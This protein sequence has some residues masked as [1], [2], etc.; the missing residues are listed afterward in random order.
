[1]S[2]RRTFHLL[3]AVPHYL[4]S[5]PYPLDSLCINQRIALVK[6][7][8]EGHESFVLAGMQRLIERDHPV[9]IV[10]TGSKEVIANLKSLGYI[11]EKLQNSPNVLF[12]PNI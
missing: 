2:S 3:Q 6:I 12:K 5:H 8:V 1:M 9:L 7:D 10:E 4:F 11:S